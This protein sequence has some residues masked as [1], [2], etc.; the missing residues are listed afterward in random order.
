MIF[1]YLLRFAED[2]RRK[3]KEAKSPYRLG[4][5]EMSMNPPLAF[6]Q[7]QKI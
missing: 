7:S 5:L 3:A 1:S 4:G 6:G 2:E